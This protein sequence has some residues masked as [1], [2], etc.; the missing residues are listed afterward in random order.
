M[1]V[2][3]HKTMDDLPKPVREFMNRV[4]DVVN[5]ECTP[6]SELTLAD[7]FNVLANSFGQVCVRTGIPKQ[8]AI[9]AIETCYDAQKLDEVQDVQE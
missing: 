7:I 8:I 5:A 9:D 3:E 2:F 1:T 6:D 4:A